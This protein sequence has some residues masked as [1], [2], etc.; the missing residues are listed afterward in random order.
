ME[1]S[2]LS[3]LIKK[4][5]GAPAFI[6]NGEGK[7]TFK[8]GGM[9]HIYEK[10][11]LNDCVSMSKM[12]IILGKH[13]AEDVRE[14]HLADIPSVGGLVY[15]LSV[16]GEN[17]SRLFIFDKSISTDKTIVD[18][19]EHI[20]EI[21]VIFDKEGT[22]EKMNSISDT[23]LPFKR[24]DV[25][26]KNIRE[27][28]SWG[29][30]EDPIILKLIDTKEKVY[31]DIVYPN[32]KVISYTAIPIYGSR[33][34]F[35]GGVLTGRDISRI[36]NLVSKMNNEEND[37]N[38]YI[39]VSDVMEEIKSMINI[40]AVSEASVFITGE[41]GTGKEVLA[42]S[43]WKKS[44]RKN[45]PFFT[46]NCGATQGDLLIQ[47]LFGY[48]KKGGVKGGSP[49]GKKGLLEA[50]DGGTLFLDEVSEL[51]LEMQKRLLRVIQEGEMI[52]IG[53]TTPQKVDVRFISATDKNMGELRN[54]AV[55]R[56]D[57]F[58]RLNV[59]PI[60]VPPLRERKE[61]LKPITEFYLQYFNKKYKKQVMLTVEAERILY[62]YDWPGNIREL[63]NVIERCVILMNQEKLTALQMERM[64]GLGGIGEIK[65]KLINELP[66]EDIETKLS[67]EK[68][69]VKDIMDINEARSICEREIIKK[70]IEK[71]GSIS[72]AAEAVGIAP[73][74]I[75]RKIKRGELEL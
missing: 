59:I 37:I 64:L 40:V 48:E 21:I 20:D 49:K 11:G 28:V 23:I 73:S 12:N 66:S 14:F 57:L 72:E 44:N 75:Y 33:G 43:I 2:I 6:V 63:K 34:D 68:I 55:F 41:Q 27:L 24:K 16:L 53:G 50:A 1:H 35:R 67:D 45:K 54:P 3:T 26:G 4:S 51:P 65:D 70:A 19:M 10:I 30:V 69:I 13:E 36:V 60:T 52:R 18:V 38:E 22:L 42:K 58:Y 39:S 74:T 56:Q 31:E 71:Y 46:I 5:I 9:R 61:D 29:L 47:E 7:M 62:N 15:D 32:G 17:S 25:V 8:N